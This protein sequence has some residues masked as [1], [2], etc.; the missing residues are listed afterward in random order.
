MEVRKHFQKTVGGQITLPRDEIEKMEKRVD[1][2]VT[3]Y[4]KEFPGYDIDDLMNIFHRH[5]E[6]T[7]SMVMMGEWRELAEEGIR[8]DDIRKE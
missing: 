5:G 1:E 7:A 8:S 4:L 2:F 3:G 6:F